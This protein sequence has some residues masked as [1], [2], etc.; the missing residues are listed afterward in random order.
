MAWI[1]EASGWYL[2]GLTWASSPEKATPYESQEIAV[3][4]MWQL[5]QIK[6]GKPGYIGKKTKQVI[7]V[8]KY[9][10]EQFNEV[11]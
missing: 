6:R 9:E 7:K 2:R 5:K 4:R 1:I 3:A 11:V 8:I 10:K